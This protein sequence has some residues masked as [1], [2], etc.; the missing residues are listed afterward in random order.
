MVAP[1]L[2]PTSVLSKYLLRE[3]Q[4]H[5]FVP[6]K[7]L[8]KLDLQ[9]RSCKATPSPTG[10]RWAR[11]RRVAAVH[12]ATTQKPRLSGVSASDKVGTSYASDLRR[13]QPSRP[14]AE[15]N[16]QTAAGI[17]TILTVS[18]SDDGSVHT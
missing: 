2:S 5:D 7:P 18:V 9:S 10:S 4:E 8:F 13:V 11:I 14:R 15:P 17:G 12:L 6:K 16:S 1:K 3:S